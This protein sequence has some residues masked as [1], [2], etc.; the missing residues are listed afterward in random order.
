MRRDT[1]KKFAELSERRQ[2]ANDAAT[3]EL[4]KR[5]ERTE[6]DDAWIAESKELAKL[7]TELRA[8]LEAEL[9]DADTKAGDPKWRRQLD[10]LECRHYI[11][12]AVDG[13]PLEGL[14]AE[15]NQELKLDGD[16]MPFDALLDD[17]ERV[18]MRADMPTI[19]PDAAKSKLRQSVIPRVFRRSDSAFFG[20]AMPTAPR[21][22][23][24]YPVLTGGVTGAMKEPGDAQDA[25]A[26]TFAATM[27]TPKRATAN[28]MLR[29]EEIAQFADL[30]S[31]LRSDM[32]MALNKLVDDTVVENDDTSPNTGSFISHATGAPNADPA[33]KATL[34][35]FDQTFADG[36][37]GLYAYERGDVRLFIGVDTQKFLSVERHD[38]TAQTYRTLVNGG[39]GTMRASTRVAAPVSDVQKAYR[40]IPNELRA[41]MPVWEGIQ[42]IR[43]PYTDAKSGEIRITAL[44][45]FG[46]DIVRGSITE[47]RFKLA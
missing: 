4:E 29:V 34:K 41:F 13:K 14:P 22:L 1:L 36:I 6:A 23:P 16:M 7:E 19:V 33:A 26:G 28:F 21:G 43:D 35:D 32:R 47:R 3:A 30:E 12:R 10:A 44:M 17:K 39:G 15:V 37:D 27:I 45:L 40:F 24:I 46:F 42:M 5:E 31:V 9:D 8:A 2:R 38:E 20:T 11:E 25:E 18:E